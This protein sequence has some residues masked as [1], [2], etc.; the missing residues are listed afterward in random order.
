VPSESPANHPPGN[1]LDRRDAVVAGLLSLALVMMLTPLAS[2]DVD[3]EHDGI[4]LKPALDVLSG[5]VL[6]RETFTQ[7][8]ALT[9][10]LQAAALWFQPTL[11]SLRF[12][13]LGVYVVIL[14]GLYAVWRQILPRSLAALAGG[15]FM[16]FLPLYER[17]WLGGH[18]LLLPWSSAYALMFQVLALFA[19]CQVVRHAHAPRWSLVAGAACACVFW[20]RQPVGII[21][22]GC[23]AVS[24]VALHFAGWAPLHVSKRMLATRL[25]AGF[26]LINAV[27]LGSVV[28]TDAVPAWWY[29][30]FTW[31]AKW[32]Q[33][34]VKNEL[35]PTFFLYPLPAASLLG[36]LLAI[37]APRLLARSK[38]AF[39]QRIVVAYYL[40]VAALIVWQHAR[41]LAWLTWRFGGW[42][43][44]FPAVALVTALVC[45]GLVFRRRSAPASTEYYLVATLA[46]AAAGALL[47]Y[48]P[49]PDPWHVLWAVAPALGL[50]VYVFWRG[51]RWPAWAAA[52]VLTAAFLPSLWAKYQLVRQTLAR[53]LVTLEHPAVLRGM[54]VPPEL[55]HRL[56]RIAAL[57][58]QV[59]RHRPGIASALIGDDALFACFTQN[60][61]NPSPYYVTW[62]GLIEPAD[63]RERWN[64]IHANR[65][66]MFL[67]S[68]RWEAVAEFYRKERYV[69]VLYFHD[70]ALEVAIPQEIADALGITTY[71]APKAT[72]S[73]APR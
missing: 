65:P 11:L 41:V 9:T 13:T 52:L 8:G 18:W 39:S 37:L 31:P 51:S 64:S 60:L 22:T 38:F 69:P 29:Q 43:L 46:A 15:L 72:G 25:I 42:T 59:E 34:L 66:V 48:Y 40:G 16:L 50:V 61:T 12:M 19:L 26:V 68:A 10:Y 49:L 44:V 7:Y 57:L 53:P 56:E 2:M 58:T 45:L 1:A 30:N 5:Q 55:A 28:L 70:D 62:A 47:Q 33:G 20:C 67:H 17:N 23:I 73:A 3:Q 54:R 35:P 36:L 32:A 14:C 21:T 4:M 27:I 6:F 71:G 24:W 63:N